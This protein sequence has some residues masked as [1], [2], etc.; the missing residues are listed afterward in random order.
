VRAPFEVQNFQTL[1]VFAEV[2]NDFV[3][4]DTGASSGVPSADSLIDGGPGDDILVGSPAVDVLFG[5]NGM[6]AHFGNAGSDY[7]FGDVNVEG[8]I[9][10]QAGD[11]LFGNLGNG[12]DPG[13][14]DRGVAL[15]LAGTSATDFVDEVEEVLEEGA[16]K[17]V[18]SWLLAMFPE[19]TLQPSGNGEFRSPQIDRLVDEAFAALR[20][21]IVR[22]TPSLISAE[23]SPRVAQ[24]SACCS[25]DVNGDGHVSP[26][27]AMLIINRLNQLSKAALVA[28]TDN[29]PP[30]VSDQIDPHDVNGDGY[31]SPVDV[32]IVINH[33]SRRNSV[34]V[35]ICEDQNLTS[36]PSDFSNTRPN[37]AMLA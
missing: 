14:R 12:N 29:N 13:F 35:T 33:L 32:V 1:G 16:L 3:H 17:G 34:C 30:D 8:T 22:P 37:K 15:V 36:V 5:G 31:V 6:D 2:G 28:S 10:P 9:V 24:Q 11:V 19:F 25:V 23:E 26:L 4:N 18:Y 20:Q 21:P 27:D 7:L